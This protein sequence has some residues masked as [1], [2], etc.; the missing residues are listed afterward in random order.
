MHVAPECFPCLLRQTIN[1][2]RSA[3]AQEAQLLAMLR[4]ITA[5]IAQADLSQTPARFS[6]PA[7]AM[8]ARLTGVADPYAAMKKET[9]A[10]ALR[11]LPKLRN[12]MTQNL[13]P[14]TLALQMAAAGNVIDAGIDHHADIQKL[15]NQLLQLSFTINDVPLFRKLLKR[16]TRLLY[17]ADNAGEIVFDVLAV[18]RIQRLGANVTVA[19]KSGPIIND[20]TLEDARTAGLPKIC[21]VIETGAASIGLDMQRVT[22]EFRAAYQ[23]ADVVIGKG[24]GHL[25]TLF[26]DPHPGLFFLL[27]VK[28]PV[29]AKSLLCTMG[30][31]VFRHA[32][33]LQA[34]A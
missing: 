19:V 31:L 23:S 1:T 26:R 25:E 8:V 21:K 10:M 32:S 22:P 24:H 14:L 13:D 5:Y 18:E 12:R 11:L 33:R 16:G 27:K 2:A 4:E 6:E 7:Y 30:D 3:G 15:L 17:L 9:N 29:V 34:V 28:C 20:A